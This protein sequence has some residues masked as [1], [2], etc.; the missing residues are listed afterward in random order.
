MKH[1]RAQI[2]GGVAAASV[3]DAV[4]DAYFQLCSLCCSQFCV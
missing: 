4:V 3:A 1:A 2:H